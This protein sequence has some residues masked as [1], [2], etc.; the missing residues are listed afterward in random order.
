MPVAPPSDPDAW[1][2]VTMQRT[3]PDQ[4]FVR[5]SL[6]AVAGDDCV[7]EDLFAGRPHRCL[8]VRSVVQVGAP[9]LELDRP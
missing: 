4:S 9:T 8:F 5:A 2:R 3:E 7:I 6:A 1:S